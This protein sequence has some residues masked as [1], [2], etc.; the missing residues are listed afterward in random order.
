MVHGNQTAFHR[1]YF[2]IVLYFFIDSSILKFDKENGII[3]SLE[4]EVLASKIE[5]LFNNKKLCQEMGEKGYD[6]V[7]N[8]SWDRVI[9]K[10]TSI[11]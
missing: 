6:Q 10:L 1:F 9:E 11:Q 4:P 7:K 3:C 2:N 8:L 5:Y